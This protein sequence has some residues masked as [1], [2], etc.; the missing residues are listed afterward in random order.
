MIGD[1][2]LFWEGGRLINCEVEFSYLFGTRRSITSRLSTLAISYS[3]SIE[4]C[5]VFVHQRETV[6]SETLSSSA[7][8]LLDFP[9]SARTALIL[10]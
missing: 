1:R 4:G 5:L 10:L 7:R 3:V 2:R 6:C 8:S 9:S